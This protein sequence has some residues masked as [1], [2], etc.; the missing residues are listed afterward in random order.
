MDCY[1]TKKD[2]NTVKVGWESPMIVTRL[3][4]HEDWKDHFYSIEEKN[5]G[6]LFD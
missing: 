3:I 5:H 1:F 6:G 4:L 2:K